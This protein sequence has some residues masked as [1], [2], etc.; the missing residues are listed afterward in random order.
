VDALVGVFGQ[1][2]QVGDDELPFGVGVVAGIG[3]VCDH[4][5][6]HVPN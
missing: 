4:T 3:L 2:A 1:Q 6:N 5:R